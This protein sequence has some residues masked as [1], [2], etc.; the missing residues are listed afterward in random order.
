VR[1]RGNRRR[2][3]RERRHGRLGRRSRRH[4]DRHAVARAEPDSQ[5]SRVIESRCEPEPHPDCQ[6]N[7]DGD[8]Q[9]ASDRNAHTDTDT[10][11]N[12]AP[13]CD[14]D[15][16]AVTGREPDR[17]RSEYVEL[18]QRPGHPLQRRVDD[19]DRRQPRHRAGRR[20]LLRGRRDVL[21]PLTCLTLQTATGGPFG[22]SAFA[23]L[24]A[25]LNGSI[26]DRSLAGNPFATASL[27]V[28]SV[29]HRRSARG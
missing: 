16:D 27:R 2:L 15:A 25:Q 21:D 24:V 28:R 20:R 9:R 4:A 5:P 22:Q 11:T 12:A 23:A 1:S 3:Q 19:G 6:S 26:L 8:H 29:L 17:R 18:D 10:D 14:A 13:H 7:R